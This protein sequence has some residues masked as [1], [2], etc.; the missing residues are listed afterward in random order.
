MGMRITLSEQVTS[1]TSQLASSQSQLQTSTDELVN[2]NRQFTALTREVIELRPLAE[3][4]KTLEET[5]KN[6][7]SNE[8]A[9]YRSY[10]DLKQ[11]LEQLH[12]ILDAVEGAPGRYAE[13][14]PN[15]YSSRGSER[16]MATRLAGTFLALSRQFM[17]ASAT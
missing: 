17:K 12:M 11:E 6:A 3:K 15:G 1:L 9:H 5:L 8:T 7:K 10:S 16:A 2:L 4:V 14:E 13:P